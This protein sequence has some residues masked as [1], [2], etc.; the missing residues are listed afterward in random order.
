MSTVSAGVDA[1]ASGP[2]RT[3]DTVVLDVV[4]ESEYEYSTHVDLAYHLAHLKPREGAAPEALLVPAA[5]PGS[6]LGSQQ[7]LA[8]ALAVEPPPTRLS[9]GRDAYG[10]VLTWFSLHAPHESLRVRATS[11]VALSPR[12]QHDP[13][14][15]APW[16][17]VRDA[18]KYYAGAPFHPEIEFVYPSPFVPLHAEL[19]AYASASFPPA[20]GV[21]AGAIDLMRRINRE[22][23]YEPE[24]TEVSTPVLDALAARRGVC[25]DFAHVMIGGLRTLG[26]AARYVSGYLLTT[27]PPGKE[28]LVGADAS[29]AWVSVH[30]PPFGWVDLDP[31]NDVIID[32]SH[33][34]V[35][36]GRDYG[37]VIPLR[38]VI[39]GGGPQTLRVGVS[40]TPA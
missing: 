25:Q 11:R 13:A 10:N 26:L 28:R 21:L 33:V 1:A 4:H 39:R 9:Q 5:P 18:L 6:A 16:E 29:H 12:T 27:P 35:A 32:R 7:L 40:V 37:D 17:E 34:S 31:T 22:F 3:S 14:A 36:V 20:S 23:A 8:F 24:T 30:C 38:G 2:P 19:G 15:S